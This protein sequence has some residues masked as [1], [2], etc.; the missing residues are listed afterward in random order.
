M[1][2]TVFFRGSSRAGTPSIAHHGCDREGQPQPS[3][4]PERPAAARRGAPTRRR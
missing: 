1:P 4:A 2:P 3:S